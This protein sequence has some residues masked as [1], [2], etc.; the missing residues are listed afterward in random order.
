MTRITFEEAMQRTAKPK[1]LSFDD[2]MKLAPPAPTVATTPKPGA[3]SKQSTAGSMS[4]P[5]AHGSNPFDFSQLPAEA[6]VAPQIERRQP[7]PDFFASR[8]D[9]TGEARNKLTTNRKQYGDDPNAW[10]PE[11]REGTVQLMHD[12]YS[13]GQEADEWTVKN[14]PQLMGFEKPPKNRKP[15]DGWVAVT[16]RKAAEWGLL[17]GK[18]EQYDPKGERWYPLRGFDAKMASAD[19][20]KAY[21]KDYFAKNFGSPTATMGPYQAFVK[22]GN[23]AVR[24]VDG[25]IADQINRNLGA[26]SEEA[27][28]DAGR[29]TL[30]RYIRGGT[31]SIA[32][33]LL[34]RG[35]AGG[36][37]KTIAGSEAAGAASTAA[38]IATPIVFSAESANDALTEARD[39][40]LKDSDAKNFAITSGAIEGGIMGIFQ[41]I[42]MGGLETTLLKG[43]GAKTA[44]EVGKRFGVALFKEELPEELLTTAADQVARRVFG[45]NP[46]D[47]FNPDGT[48]WSKK[49]GFAPIAKTY[50]DTIGQTAVAMG[51][52]HG[53]AAAK[54]ALSKP[55]LPGDMPM[56]SPTANTPEQEAADLEEANRAA[57]PG[58]ATEAVEVPAPKKMQPMPVGDAAVREWA[59]KNPEAAAP[60]VEAAKSGKPIT[61]AMM[62]E[63]GFY[64]GRAEERGTF[65]K[66]LAGVELPPLVAEQDTGP[67][68]QQPDATVQPKPEQRSEA[69]P[70]P[71]ETRVPPTPPA[72]P[73]TAAEAAVANEAVIGFTTER[74]RRVQTAVK[75]RFG[76]DIEFVEPEE[77]HRDA[78]DFLAARGVTARLYTSKVPFGRRPVSGFAYPGEGVVYFNATA[79]KGNEFW[80]AVGHEWSHA[81]GA[82]QR[83][84]DLPEEVLEEG[85]KEYAKNANP[86]YRKWL[87]DHPDY[88]TREAAAKYVEKLM[89]NPDFRAV[90]QNKNPTLW[91][92]IWRAIRSLVGDY[93]PADANARRVL[94]ELTVKEAEQEVR[95]AAPRRPL[96][97]QFADLSDQQLAQ[98]LVDFG[99]LKKD[100]FAK[101]KNQP[102]REALE[103]L[104][105]ETLF[106]AKPPKIIRFEKPVDAEPAVEVTNQGE[107]EA[108]VE[109]PPASQQADG[110]APS[111]PVESEVVPAEAAS[112]ATPET[113]AWEPLEE[114]QI[115]TSPTPEV[116][117]TSKK[118]R[119]G[120]KATRQPASVAQADDQYSLRMM[121]KPGSKIT[122]SDV[123]K[124]FPGAKVKRHWYWKNQWHVLLPNGR[125]AEVREV[126]EIPIDWN[127]AEK[128]LGHKITPAER[129]YYQA[130]GQTN[131]TLSSGAQTNPLALVRLARDTA[132]VGTMRHEAFHV[133]DEF[134]MISEQERASLVRRFSSPQKSRVQ[135]NEDIA[136]ARETWTGPQG[137]RRRVVQFLRD[138]VRRLG[139]GKLLKN[140]GDEV[141]RLMELEPFWARRAERMLEGTAYQ[142]AWHGTP[143]KV[144]RFSTSKIGTGEGAQAYGHGLYFAGKKEVGE[145]Y[146]DK[147]SKPAKPMLRRIEELYDDGT[148][149]EDA[150]DAVLNDNHFTPT[151]MKLLKALHA[152]DWLG[153]DWPH[154]AV[155]A[156]LGKD[157]ENMDPSPELVA[158][159][160]EAKA[161]KGRLYQVDLKPAED[162]YLL[163]DKPLS[164]QSDKVKAAIEQSPS[165]PW[166]AKQQLKETPVA[167]DELR[168][169]WEQAKPRLT[170]RAKTERTGPGK[171]INESIP[172]IEK[173]L[174]LSSKYGTPAEA[175]SAAFHRDF[176]HG[177]MRSTLDLV[178]GNL[179][180]RIQSATGRDVYQGLAK[181]GGKPAASSAL[182]ELGIRGIKYL[183]GSSRG[184]GE[185]THN[186]VIFDDADVEITAAYQLR[187]KN[188]PEYVASLA[189]PGRTQKVRDAVDQERLDREQGE[190]IHDEQTAAAATKRLAENKD[191]EFQN[192]LHKSATDQPLDHVE[193]I[194]A[195]RLLNE[196][197]EAVNA[198]DPASITRASAI[199]VAY[200]RTASAE[201]RAFR[202]LRD[203]IETPAQ[204]LARMLGEATLKPSPKIQ[205]Q[206]DQ[207]TKNA[208][209]E[210]RIPQLEKLYEDHRKEVGKLLGQLKEIG[211]EPRQFRILAKNE[212]IAL[213]TLREISTR[214]STMPDAFF[215]YWINSILSGPATHVRNITGNTVNAGLYFTA[216]KLADATVNLFAKKKTGAQFGEF[217]HAYAAMIRSFGKAGQNFI[218]TWRNE[219]NAFE[220]DMGRGQSDSPYK[221]APAIGG[222][223]IRG[224]R[225]NVG[226]GI[227]TPTR[228][229]RAVDA[230]S[231]TITSHGIASERAYRVAHG[232]GLTGKALTYR[233]DKL[234]ADPES[235]AWRQAFEKSEE[236]AFRQKG[237]ALN[238]GIKKSLDPLQKAYGGRYIVTFKNTMV[239][240]FGAGV[241]LTP[242][243]MFTTLAKARK[244]E[245]SHITEDIG[246]NLMSMAFFAM[247]LAQ[248]EDDPWITGSDGIGGT[249]ENRFS[250][251]LGDYN[252][253]GHKIYWYYGFVEPFATGAGLMVDM[254]RAFKSP[255]KLDIPRQLVVALAEQ[256]KNKTFAGNLGDIAEAVTNP[257]RAVGI[258]AE[259]G[260]NFVTSW[261]PNLSRSLSRESDDVVMNRKIRGIDKEE[262]AKRFGKR[263]LQNAELGLQDVIDGLEDFPRY[264]VFGDPH[265]RSESPIPS[266]DLLFRIFSPM[267]SSA[268]E[269]HPGNKFM[270]AWKN[271][272]PEDVDKL[273][274]SSDTTYTVEGK[275]KSMTDAQESQFHRFSGQ[276]A[277][278]LVALGNYDSENPTKEQWDA[279]SD[280]FT[281]ARK[282]AKELLVAQWT[283][284]KP[285]SL[286]S[287][288]V[289]VALARKNRQQAND[290]LAA[291]AR[292]PKRALLKK[293]ESALQYRERR[294]KEQAQT[295]RAVDV[296]R[297]TTPK[298]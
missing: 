182:R 37:A 94:E 170:E 13:P 209:E 58:S 34:T 280:D 140:N 220:M 32:T 26:I 16:N 250:V 193:R 269:P 103:D 3:F 194:I 187:N 139:F 17:P 69:I 112:N 24:A 145:F 79:T 275:T 45:V 144:D 114:S 19:A 25:D 128:Q 191:G 61:Q 156:A 155:R 258:A 153:F 137:I 213:A 279:F 210:N 11:F 289:A 276:V 22:F 15:E 76:E 221:Y 278:Q 247:L 166:S 183:D 169:K 255:D 68:S 215:E 199:L 18:K 99:A 206:I 291:D 98:V 257:K 274:Y 65:A 190:V 23:L 33:V 270:S 288:K 217:K 97:P 119:K 295:A 287:E 198:D 219:I 181:A 237:G 165:V 124:M 146:R 93:K 2:A 73:E 238:Q 60:L 204:R 147:L 129:H 223:T 67:S 175:F 87:D 251:W 85:R 216:T 283:T 6:E 89:S 36:A 168:T 4:L 271:Q 96:P 95:Q 184:K 267:S 218:R 273:L 264:D 48:V 235:I 161:A 133:A 159:V 228:F 154:Q 111:V 135:Q 265:E 262:Y 27:D 46:A 224:K 30:R 178:N 120:N 205:K 63:T 127:V 167:W 239:N 277:K 5:Q 12:A 263:I 20:T 116:T 245:T 42:G 243:G 172:K 31:E 233:M 131:L 189:N 136:K 110:V 249:G 122:S 92:K 268:Y 294:A 105:N 108:A 207:E 281:D 248:D 192:L 297:R 123:Q 196:A 152:D 1:R 290:T 272:H 115:E 8:I 7:K 88:W 298:K 284:G 231:Q 107:S 126:D 225:Y 44:R 171:Y 149:R 195:N 77:R 138:L 211:I 51:L 180:E 242:L 173:L 9:Y 160:E 41:L 72:A 100:P 91:Q 125:R 83:L 142:I 244:G 202:Q 174:S 229:L 296:F 81:T 293:G 62:G 234:L 260:A 118:V 21:A 266:T 56:P 241:S 14:A 162:E 70:L 261:L 240:I 117:Q 292:N 82:D 188:T 113:Q 214:R 54:A 285:A 121:R 222:V 66:S 109:P 39:A 232:E 201:G 185:G 28:I 55:E 143:H 101:K 150:I 90:L 254:S 177:T 35:L 197:Y 230:W 102:S 130:A 64:R 157:F 132:D 253:K 186:Y 252:E 40:G 259:A 179:G 158:A 141:M 84:A 59:A 208:A 47:Q 246:K 53:P 282:I 134:G 75:Q 29:S 163:W 86:T 10:S 74:R 49:H 227:R 236:L 200:D 226:R 106:G 80:G 38:Q 57:T 78:V 71:T 164:E 151:E 286:D 148:A 43:V 256:V 203:P 52:A 212:R 176:D 104:L 50:I